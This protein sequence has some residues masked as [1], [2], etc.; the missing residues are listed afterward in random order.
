[1]EVGGKAVTAARILIGTGSWPAMPDIPGPQ[2][3]PRPGLDHRLLGR[4]PG[5]QVARRHRTA[6]GRVA[7]LARSERL[8]E[9]GPG[10]VHL[11]SEGGNGHQVDAD[12]YHSHGQTLADHLPMTPLR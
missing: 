4:P 11:L 3:R 2:A 6:I 9:H 8:G 5:R 10:L 1:M 12:A 7:A